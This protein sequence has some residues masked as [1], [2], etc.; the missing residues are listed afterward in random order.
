[1]K[2]GAKIRRIR[3]GHGIPMKDMA[4]RLD[5]SETGYSKIERDGV[6]INLEKLTLIANELDMKP[7]ELISEDRITFHISGGN[8]FGIGDNPI[9]HGSTEKI[10]QLYEDKIRLLED[11]CDLLQDK[12][13]WM[14][15][16]IDRLRR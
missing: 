8:N 5:M 2:I 14:Q 13:V 1:M 16:E 3:E 10:N 4:N 6:G 12:V 9:I 7:E 15:S 11:K